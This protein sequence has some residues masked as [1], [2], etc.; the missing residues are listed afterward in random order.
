MQHPFAIFTLL[1]G[2]KLDVALVIIP[3]A[4]WQEAANYEQF[5]NLPR[6]Q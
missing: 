4:K 6:K 3:F 5:T 2:L 1:G